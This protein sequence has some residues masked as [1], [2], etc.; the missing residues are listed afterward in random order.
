MRKPRTKKTT[1]PEIDPASCLRAGTK[2]RFTDFNGSSVCGWVKT[3]HQI[4]GYYVV[5][6]DNEK[7]Y[8]LREDEM[9]RA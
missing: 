4:D 2:V 1:T 6:T 5:M 8:L 7:H 3:D 9:E